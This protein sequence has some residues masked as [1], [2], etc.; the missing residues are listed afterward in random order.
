[1]IDERLEYLM[2]RQLDGRI[3]AAEQLELNKAL[4]RSPEAHRLF[5]EYQANDAL[6]SEAL[7]K[8]FDVPNVTSFT[9]PASE[10]SVRNRW[11]GGSMV[12][13]AFAAAAMI[14]LTV[15]IRGLSWSK[16]EDSAPVQRTQVISDQPTPAEPPA[17][18]DLNPA[19]KPLTPVKVFTPRELHEYM[20]RDFV[21]VM[22]EQARNIY[23]LEMDRP[24]TNAV[25]VSV[26]Y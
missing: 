25:P 12:R 19:P 8:A 15:M 21:A 10:I 2:T 6:A 24:Q 13:L 14:A 16:S 3:S 7:H 23:L 5:D 20:P 9:T 26:R 17:I 1:M 22:D 18:A 4:I 11:R